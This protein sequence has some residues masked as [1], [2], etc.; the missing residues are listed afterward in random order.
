MS[1]FYTNIEVQQEWVRDVEQLGSKPKIW[2][3][4]E[5]HRWLFKESRENTGEDWSEK[6]ASEVAAL[7][8][9]PTHHVE[10]ASR[11]TKLGCAAKSFLG[12]GQALAHGNELL[13]GM[14][15]GYDKEKVRG[16]SDHTF[17]NIVTVLEK[18]F[19]SPRP[20]TVACSRMAGYL[21][22]DAL[23]GNTDRHHQN[24]GVVV[25]GKRGA[26]QV[27]LVHSIQLAP[28]F[29]HA[30]SLGRELNDETRLRLMEQ[31]AL[32]RYA[33]R[34][35]G[36]IFGNRLAK[37]GLSPIATV[38]MLAA[39]YPLFFA[40]WRE[41]LQLLDMRRFSTILDRVPETRMSPAARSFALAF[42]QSNRKLLL[43]IP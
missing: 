5:G 14:I 39:R 25:Q 7:V 10:L 17:E 13:G 9:L 38:E 42:L 34:A 11:G 21:V 19:E 28:T 15:T 22:L 8:G 41:K 18:L 20:R 43:S 27:L 31:N 35:R 33:R 12:P 26:D 3:E 1:E 29:D 6:V 2:F 23:V 4:L 24:W 40:P 37:H 30:S 16:Q 32:E 36:G